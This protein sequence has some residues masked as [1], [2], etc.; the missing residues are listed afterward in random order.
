MKES[1]LYLFEILM[2][3]SPTYTQNIDIILTTKFTLIVY[4]LFS[5]Y[6]HLTTC[7]DKVWRKMPI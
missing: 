1:S 2:L 4:T 5:N 3:V 6:I 7:L